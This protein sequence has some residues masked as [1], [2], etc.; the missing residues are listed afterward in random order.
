MVLSPATYGLLAEFDTPEKLLAAA[1]A[2]RLKGYRRMDAYSPF[3]V[4]G[5]A[6]TLGFRSNPMALIMLAGGVVGGLGGYL[7]QYWSTVI[8]YPLIVAGRPLHSWP[9]YIPITFELT[10]LGSG[11]AGFL[12]LWVINRLPMPYHPVF[13]A[14]EFLRASTDRFFLCLEAHDPLFSKEESEIFLATLSPLSITLL[15]DERKWEAG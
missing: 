3:P 14:P 8:S 5:L 4:P 10:V 15:V 9:S 6:A 11:L 2:A 7:M 12:G 13:G 1:R